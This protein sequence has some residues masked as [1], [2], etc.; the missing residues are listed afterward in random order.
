MIQTPDGLRILLVLHSVSQRSVESLTGALGTEAS[1]DKTKK[2]HE[3]SLIWGQSRIEHSLKYERCIF[4]VNWFCSQGRNRCCALNLNLQ[5]TSGS[6]FLNF[7]KSENCH[8][9]VFF[10]FFWKKS[11]SNCEVTLV[12][13]PHRTDS[14]HER[15][16]LKNWWYYRWLFDFFSKKLRCMIVYLL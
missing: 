7:S 13:K 6:G 12:Q 10:F 4:L 8:F 5:R 14:F 3:I 1:L 11:E 15:S 9:W 2:C 16:P